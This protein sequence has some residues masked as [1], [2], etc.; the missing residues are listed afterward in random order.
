MLELFLRYG[1]HENPGRYTDLLTDWGTGWLLLTAGERRWR[2]KVTPAGVD[3][4]TVDD[5]E[6][7]PATVHGE[8]TA[9][10]MWL[11]NRGDDVTITGDP[12]LTTR[13]RALLDRAMS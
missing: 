10:L 1:S 6:N 9:L 2:I 7:A 3:T 8:P 11:Y 4:A 12:E 5:T 13:T